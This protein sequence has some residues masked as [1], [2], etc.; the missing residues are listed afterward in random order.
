MKM[1]M[2][3]SKTLKTTKKPAAAPKTRDELLGE[4]TRLMGDG[5]SVLP[6]KMPA[7]GDARSGKIPACKHGVKDATND[8]KKFKKLV[9]LLPKFNLGMA[10]GE[11]SD[12]VVIDIDPR[13]GGNK[14]F[15][16]LERK[17]GPLPETVTVRTGG[18]G[19]H[20]YFE[21]PRKH[22]RSCT[23]G[24]GVDFLAD[25]KFAVVPPSIHGSGRQY[26]WA[27]GSSPDSM[28]IERL[29]R[30]WRDFIANRPR[31]AAS[32]KTG[33][34][35][36]TAIQV[37]S[38]NNELTRI[39][40]Q[41]R[42][43]GLTEPEILDALTV[44]NKARCNPPLE[45]AELSE[46]ASNIAKYPAGN[47]LQLAD[48]GEQLAQAVLDR[49]FNG[50]AQLRHEKDGQFWR[51]KG[52]HWAP[53]D[54]KVLQHV[55]LDTAKT[56]P[57]KAHTKALVHEAFALLVMLQS[58]E[59]DLLHIHDDPPPV[60]NVANGELWLRDDGTI[61]IQPHDPKTGMRHVLPVAYDPG[62]KCPEFDKALQQIFRDAE[63][64]G[65]VIRFMNEL[66]GYVIQPRRHHALIVIFLGRGNNGKT[67]FTELLRRLIGPGQIYSGRVDD[68]EKNQFSIGNLFGKHLYID[69]DIKAGTKLPDGTLKKISEAKTL[70]GERKFKDQFEFKSRA[71]P[72][73]L[74]NNIPSLADLSH[75]MMRRL[76]VVP[77]TRI[78]KEHETDRQLFERIAAK[79][80]SGVLNRALEGWK[81]LQTKGR[82][83]KSIDMANARKELLAHANPLQG[84]IDECCEKADD[85]TISMDKFYLRYKA[86]ADDNGYTMTQTKPT[87]R[88]NL[89]HMNYRVPRRASGR[90]IIGLKIRR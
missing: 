51:W 80:L 23:I 29:P 32:T 50:G 6:I 69:D 81:R 3:D 2:H 66:I 44:T 65:T 1:N 75:G 72:I 4:A 27:T 22:L 78:F 74:C 60:I 47:A 8:P 76:R 15:E 64:P 39:G 61:D 56:L 55:I 38:R 83:T 70:T 67:S 35:Q 52:T 17:L 90:V 12:I 33:P 30:P 7:A 88:K 5:F 41:M 87:A 24:Q 37:G 82:F 40:G 25:G 89:E 9:E 28:W 53:V 62:A 77:F 43:A 13:N 42:R 36:N 54:D 79:E 26:H 34:E 20:R 31:K 10:T 18:G 16:A 58:S 73:L 21:A 19:T 63:K 71:F 85:V 45:P 84:F 48:P 46:I 86:W 49:H 57:I 11:P 14:T 68:L 59:D